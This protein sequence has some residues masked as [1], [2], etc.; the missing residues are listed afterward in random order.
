M[1]EY[2][3]VTFENPFGGF[4]VDFPDLPDCV[5]FAD[6]RQAARVIAAETLADYI[7]EMELAGEAIPEPSSYEVIQTDAANMGCDIIRVRAARAVK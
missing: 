7:E 3:A 6:S 5:T 2:F 1:R 4:V